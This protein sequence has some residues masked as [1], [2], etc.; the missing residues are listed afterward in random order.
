MSAEAERYVESVQSALRL[1][2][3]FESDT[4]LRLMDLHERTGLTRSRIIRLAGT[5]ASEGFLSYDDASSR[6]F[7]GPNLFRAGSLLAKRYADIS[8]AVRPALRALVAATGFTALFSILNGTSRLIL[9][10]EEPEEAIRY[11]VP[12][13]TS[14]P[15]TAGASG[16]VMLAFGGAE[17][18]EK[19][20]R[21]A[22][23]K[24][25]E[26]KALASRLAEIRK[27][28][29]DL[30]RS[31]LTAHAFAIAVPVVAESGALFG[32]LTAAGPETNYAEPAGE[33]ALALL[34]EQA[35]LIPAGA[36]MK[37]QAPRRKSSH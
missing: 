7:L 14:R 10:K 12:E 25:A 36:L 6:Y 20:S 32:V 15:V 4:G 8:E 26:L 9:S 21:M 24:G 2:T 29:H 28:G 1:L 13:G 31:E 30:S 11:T 23:P 27:R 17:L 16:R 22:E 18:W 3:C 37:Q 34:K 35:R 19:V 33:A 5:L